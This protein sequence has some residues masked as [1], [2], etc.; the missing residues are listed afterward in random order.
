MARVRVKRS[1]VPGKIP[2][3]TDVEL[4]EFAINTYDGKVFIK[5]DDGTE[6]IIEISGDSRSS[7]KYQAFV[8]DGVTT[9]F[10][11]N[12]FNL[13]EY[14]LVFVGGILEWY[15]HSRVGNVVTFV[16]A[17]MDGERVIIQN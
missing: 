6:S 4:G 3:V 13:N 7:M 14:Y 15:G 8:A 16:N 1:A 11:V 12:K 5:K 17:P 9:E 10:T 2:L